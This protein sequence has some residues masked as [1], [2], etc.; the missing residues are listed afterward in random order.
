MP[1]VAGGATGVVSLLIARGAP[2]STA[3]HGGFTPL[4]GAAANGNRDMV[5]ALLAAGA[6]PHA[7]AGNGQ[8]ALDLAM[9]K[10]HSD[11]AA[12]LDM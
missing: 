10:G 2:V 4:M 5:K 12:L 8:S 3:Q 7:R 9:A 1:L 6:D 11:V